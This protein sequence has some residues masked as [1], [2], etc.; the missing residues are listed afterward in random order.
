[1]F[2]N[3]LVETEGDTDPNDFGEAKQTHGEGGCDKGWATL[4]AFPSP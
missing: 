3:H 4:P 1:M 2:Q